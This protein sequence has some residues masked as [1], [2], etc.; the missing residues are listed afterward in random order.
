MS[1][2]LE[3]RLRV[4]F[5][6]APL[7][8][9]PAALRS[10]LMTVP[11][12]VPDAA[13]RPRRWRR[14]PLALAAALVI[15]VVGI[16]GFGVLNNALVGPVGPSPSELPAPPPSVQVLDATQLAAAIAAQR[17][18]G[19]EPQ[20]VVTSVGIDGA[21]RPGPS[22]RECAKPLGTCT[23]IGVLAGIADW[24]G[25]VTIRMPEDGSGDLPTPTTP[26]DL[27]G[28]VALR[29]NGYAPIEFLGH[30]DLQGAS[31]QVDVPALL[32][33]TATAP[34]GQVRAVDG[35]LVGNDQ[36]SCGP[37]RPPLPRPFACPPDRALLTASPIRPKV[38][39]DNGFNSS[40][41]DGAILVQDG[42]Y[43]AFAPSP[44]ND[45]LNDVPR[46][47]LYLVRMVAVDTADCPACRGW[48]IVGRLDAAPIPSPSSSAAAWDG[49]LAVLSAAEV[50]DR[51]TG[52]QM[53]ALGAPL[54]VDGK[55]ALDASRSCAVTD[56]W[57]VL[58]HLEGTTVPVFATGYTN[59]LLPPDDA[60]E[61]NSVMAFS[62]ETTGLQYLG[63]MGYYNG[64]GFEHPISSLTDLTQQP[65]GPMV[66]AVRG[67]L[68]AGPP[69]PCPAPL[70]GTPRNTPF[71]GCP[72][73]WLAQ[74]GASPW[75]WNG[76]QIGFRKREVALEVQYGA[77]FDFAPNP[78]TGQG[79]MHEPRYGTY[80][81]RLVTDTSHRDATAA[82][83][84]QVV[85]RLDPA[86]AMGPPLEAPLPSLAPTP[87]PTPWP[88]HQ[89]IC[90]PE[91]GQ[92]ASG[93][94][95]DPC[96]SAIAAALA[97]VAAG[98]NA[99]SRL[100]L[101]PGNFECGEFWGRP[102]TCVESAMPPGVAMHG[103]ITFA[104]TDKVVVIRLVRSQPTADD[105]EPAWS[106]RVWAYEVPPAGWSM[107]GAP[108]TPYGLDCGPLAATPDLCA[109]A[110]A[111]ALELLSL[112]PKDVIAVRIAEPATATCGAAGP[113]RRPTVIVTA[114]L[115]S[116]AQTSGV[117]L[118]RTES[119]WVG[120]SQIR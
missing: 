41:P 96:P 83:G 13:R 90:T 61:T 102:T 50:Q 30:V 81:V 89:A 76:D 91:A 25:A 32:A 74:D 106:A 115:A 57:C 5:H 80:L 6:D 40:T 75:F 10:A 20:V 104:G 66:V 18:G 99:P 38:A 7:P 1:E 100:Y 22:P 72:G 82:R 73:A 15:A 43:R 63:Y 78:A 52:L 53:S 55:L 8:G 68:T 33:A 88:S 47:G 93:F 34:A 29:L 56:D 62:V 103:W 84:W 11:D 97:A 37:Y 109:L 54:L 12:A 116:G 105:P 119:G 77:Y 120:L 64:V 28:P 49:T 2:D 46:R 59:A 51:I 3:R 42:A 67:W 87:G 58:G 86:P 117:G 14:L 98:A 107:P 95:G 26:A 31:G 36:P 17:A 114:T 110:A 65:L 9:A 4:A 48:L 112:A 19:L 60:S 92:E 16:A 111:T 85:G 44:A 69:L 21:N 118:V 79:G 39:V 70:P 108:A 27:A 45:G 23:V 101:E 24:E 35:W 71:E 94:V 113:C